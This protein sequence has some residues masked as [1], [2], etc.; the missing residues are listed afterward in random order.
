MIEKQQEHSV[1]VTVLLPA[2]NEEKAIAGTVQ[3]INELY[4]D[5]EVLVI[6]DGSSDNTLKVAMEAGANVWPHPYNIG[7]GAAVKNRFTYGTRRMDC[8]DGC[9][10][11]A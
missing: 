8:H 9:R 10:R 4:P 11:S 6:D 1:S 7:N 2:F 3:K 5:F